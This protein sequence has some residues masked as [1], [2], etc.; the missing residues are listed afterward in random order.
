MPQHAHEGPLCD[1]AANTWALGRPGADLPARN[2]VV[3][4][5]GSA[6]QAITARMIVWLHSKKP[7]TC[8]PRQKYCSLMPTDKQVIKLARQAHRL[9]LRSL[10]WSVS[11]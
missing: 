5:A 9:W 1:V 10:S 2:S 7:G 11:N 6:S 8:L 4:Q 3:C